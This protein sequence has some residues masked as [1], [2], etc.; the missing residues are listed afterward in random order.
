MISLNWPISSSQNS[1][2]NTILSYFTKKTVVPEV[3]SQQLARGQNSHLAQHYT[4]PGLL[5]PRPREGVWGC[6]GSCPGGACGPGAALRTH[7]L[8]QAPRPEALGQT[9]GW[10]HQGS[11]GTTK[12]GQGGQYD[13]RGRRKE[14]WHLT[15]KRKGRRCWQLQRKGPSRP[16]LEEA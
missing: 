1:F 5:R 4:P 2:L 15:K 16:S 7:A 6:L 13:L 14:S 12:G 3:L 8:S 9:G 11:K 10:H